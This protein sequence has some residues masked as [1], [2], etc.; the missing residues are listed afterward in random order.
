MSARVAIGRFG[1]ATISVILGVGLLAIPAAQAA[2]VRAA[3]TAAGTGASANLP[4]TVTVGRAPGAIA[5]DTASNAMWVANAGDNTVTEISLATRRV[6]ATVALASQPAS[7]AAGS[8]S[9]WVGSQTANTVTQISETSANVV[10]TYQVGDASAPPMFVT[11][12]Q[13]DGVSVASGGDGTVWV[14]HN[15]ALLGPHQAGGSPGG[16]ALADGAFWVTDS[17]GDTVN[18]VR[19]TSSTSIKVGNHPTE[20]VADQANR[21]VWVANQGDG[22]L[23]KIDFA[24]SPPSVVATY[25]VGTRDF[26]FAISANDETILIADTAA[27]SISVISEATGHTVGTVPV[28]AAPDAIA[29]PADPEPGSVWIANRNDGTVTVLAPPFI[30]S[31]VPPA[32]TATTG[33]P[34]SL[35]LTAAGDPVPQFSAQQLPAGLTIAP[36]GLL[37]GTPAANTGGS[38]AILVKATNSLGSWQVFV[39]LQVNQPTSFSVPWEP[40]LTFSAGET[41]FATIAASGYPSP[42]VTESGRLPTGMAFSSIPGG[43]NFN[44]STAQLSGT[45]GKH[46]GGIYPITLTAANSLGKTSKTYTITVDQAPTITS[47]PRAMF[48]VGR[49]GTFTIRTIGFPIAHLKVSGKLPKGLRLKFGSYGTATITGKPASSTRHGRYRIMLE[50]ANSLGPPASQVLKIIIR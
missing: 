3:A 19:A 40:G 49:R 34:F 38:Y 48:R 36:T 45:A 31:A 14:I 35:Q 10:N 11:N 50:A 44:W 7:L 9:V 24:N 4:A 22:T 1:W 33:R 6:I 25:P 17:A 29:V 18:I 8:G 43:L 46:S 5:A 15:G 16:I 32:L 23:S 42:A 47:P 21:L 12:A 2:R 30:T 39:F 20:V 41:S 37:S 26:A 28:G 13:A 27:S